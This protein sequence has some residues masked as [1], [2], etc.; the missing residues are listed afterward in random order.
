MCNRDSRAQE[1]TI[2]FAFDLLYKY[3]RATHGSIVVTVTHSCCY[4]SNRCVYNNTI[5]CGVH[6]VALT[7][8]PPLPA[9]AA[10]S[11]GT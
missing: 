3:V 10:G 4:I 7:A 5:M 9:A 8:A 2:F 11:G 1:S 6:I